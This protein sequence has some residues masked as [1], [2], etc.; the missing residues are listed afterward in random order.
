MKKLFI[1]MG[2]LLMAGSLLAQISA[3]IKVNPGFGFIKS[4]T[5][6]P[7]L[8]VEKTKD[9]HI[10]NINARTGAG[11]NIGLGVFGQYNIT[12]VIA[13]MAEPSFNLLY[14]RIYLNYKREEL[15][16]DGS[17]NQIRISSIAKLR[18]FYFNLPVL[19]R[20]T[21]LERKKLYALGGFSVNVNTKP[22]IHSE[23][24]RVDAQYKFN[25]LT[26]SQVYT[27]TTS[28]TLNQYSAAQFNLILGI[29][30]TFRRNLKNLSVDIRYNY[31]V[32]K[33]AMYNTTDQILASSYGN[34]VFSSSQS[35]NAPY[36][37][38]NFQ[39]PNNF[40]MS[41]I[42]VVVKYTLYKK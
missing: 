23:E 22:H 8:G 37:S 5:L 27:S 13:V 29:G 15:D 34:A 39:K 41:V 7:M 35:F 17:G 21:F 6:D 20:Y 38:G 1:F 3:G 42:N 4:S 33:S 16:K 36:P 28:A 11:F 31:P 32:S 24:T 14:S 25:N 18:I 10:L 12:P 40:K 26:E 19:V 2:C 9:S 30:K